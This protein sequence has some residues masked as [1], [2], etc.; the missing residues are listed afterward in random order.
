MADEFLAVELVQRETVTTF[1]VVIVV[2][3]VGNRATS[4]LQ[5]HVVGSRVELFVLIER[6]EVL[7]DN[8]AVGN[9][10]A[11]EIERNSRDQNAREHVGAHKPFK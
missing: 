3:D 7:F 11:T 5:H 6:L 10:V 2:L 1:G 8:V 9:N 4:H